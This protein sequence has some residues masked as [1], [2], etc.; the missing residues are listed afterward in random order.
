MNSLDSREAFYAWIETGTLDKASLKLYDEGIYNKKYGIPYHSTSIKNAANVFILENVA[1][2]RKV[3]LDQGSKIT[4]KQWEVKLIR[5]ACRTYSRDRFI[6]WA[7]KNPFVLKYPDIIN[8]RW[9]GISE[10]LNKE[11]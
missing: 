6:K 7:K 10:L 4:D 9:I 3:Y 8:K 1:E 2:A 5:Y 11:E